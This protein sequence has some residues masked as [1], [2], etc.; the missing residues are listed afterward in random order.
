MKKI[1]PYK[2][3]GTLGRGGMGTVFRGRNETSGELH[4]VKVLAPVYS[5]D[6][7]FRGRFESEI[8]ALLKLDHPN[9]VRLIS[10][11]QDDG[12]LYFSMELVDGSSLFQKQK[13]RRTFN[14]REILAIGKD[15]CE[16]LRHAHDRGIIHRDLKPGNLMMTKDGSVKIADFGIAKSFGSSQNTGDN[17]VGTM[18]FMSPEQARG[19][20][21]TI[22]SD[23]YSLGT[24][25][26]TLLSGRP[27]FS[28]NSIEESLRNLTRV[29]APSIQS[30]VPSIPSEIDTIISRLME[31]KPEK[32]IA[33]ALAVHHKLSEI[34]EL[35]KGSSEAKT[36][37]NR[38]VETSDEKTILLGAREKTTAKRGG[39]KKKSETVELS[40]AKTSASEKTRADK[41]VVESEVAVEP[42]SLAPASEKVKRPDFYNKVTKSDLQ[43][44][45]EYDAE[46]AKRSKGFLST[47][48]G[49]LA[50]VLMAALGTWYSTRKPSADDLY[51]AIE[52]SSPRKVLAE[53]QLFL[54][55]YPEDSRVEAVQQIYKLGKANQ[56]YTQLS[57]RLKVRSNI[58]GANRL[59]DIE[60]QFLDIAEL[61]KT[62]YEEAH[63][64]MKAF[65]TVHDSVDS[66]SESDQGCVEAAKSFCAKIQ[67]DAIKHAKTN[68]LSIQ[69]ALEKARLSEP[70]RAAEIYG[71]IIELY[72]P[73]VE[74][75]GNRE[76]RALVGQAQDLLGLIKAGKPRPNIPDPVLQSEPEAPTNPGEGNE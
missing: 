15:V 16:G 30:V 35:L 75:R 29:P 39:A 27:P 21:V 18:D 45:N 64:K 14:W 57:N 66:L 2:L 73:M 71:S 54:E 7:H 53:A 47:L 32:R 36:A 48:I 76:V 22:R 31:K 65:V 43:G 51:T 33:T 70:Q 10:F 42:Y 4:A 9:I 25:M 5:N 41:T 20:P 56:Y 44:S 50:V 17:V 11:G 49:L 8:K 69:S 37:E 46:V 74:G 63:M 24:V 58:V 68:L 67:E 62:N 19:E 1:G 40:Q 13:E 38:K 72:G 28:G 60:R 61:S 55:T 3:E 6:D 26:F 59:S 34:E 12:N 23:L 52:A